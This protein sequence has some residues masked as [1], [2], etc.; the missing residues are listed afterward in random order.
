M[1]SWYFKQ[2]I[3]DDSF[4]LPTNLPQTEISHQNCMDCHWILCIHTYIV[5]DKIILVPLGMICDHFG[6]A[7]TQLATF[8]FWS[9][10]YFK[11]HQECVRSEAFSPP[12]FVY[13]PRFGELKPWP[14][15][16]HLFCMWSLNLTI[17]CVCMSP[18]SFN[19]SL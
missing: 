9:V 8:L 1:C 3:R 6:D 18:K 15:W 16:Q 4:S 19:L 12:Y 11:P 7:K 2:L 17:Y 13:L 5:S 14:H 10:L